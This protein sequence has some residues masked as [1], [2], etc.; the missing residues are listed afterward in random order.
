VAEAGKPESQ[1]TDTITELTER[2]LGL[3]SD[4]GRYHARGNSCGCTDFELPVLAAA[5]RRSSSTSSH[6]G[7]DRCSVLV[8][9]Q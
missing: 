2:G 7:P 6:N 5:Q 3:G 8:H 1:I 4:H 9:V